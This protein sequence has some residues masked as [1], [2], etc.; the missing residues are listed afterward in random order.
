[1]TNKSAVLAQLDRILSSP[2]FR[3]SKRDSSLLRYLVE[4]TL[5]GE[6]EHLKERVLGVAVFARPADY[7]N[8]ADPVVRISAGET[9]KR[10]A[11]YYHGPGHEQ[12]IRIELPV[13][14][15]VPQFI[16]LPLPAE[17]PPATK[18]PDHP[19]NPAPCL[20]K[21]RVRLRP[22]LLIS[23]VLCV[24]V[25]TGVLTWWPPWIR[26][27]PLEQFW[28]PFLA[29][30]PPTTICVGR[31]RLIEDSQIGEAFNE[32]PAIAW[33]ETLALAKF[34]IFIGRE[35][36][37]CQ[38]RRDDNVTFQE[39]AGAPA[40]LI[41]GL[42]NVWVIR[43][44]EDLRFTLQAE[45]GVRFIRD[46][47]N[48]SSKAWSNPVPAAGQ[49]RTRDFGLITRLLESRSGKPVLVVSGTGGNG[50]DA[51]AEFVT[52]RSN[53]DLMARNAPVGWERKNLQIVLE[54]NVINGLSGPAK[55]VALHV[56]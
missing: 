12:E 41:G 39:L 31:R 25:F 24:V 22:P 27:T 44:T 5:E 28:R 16:E 26:T 8:S 49:Q 54:A 36:K 19:I 15:Y 17:A 2:S 13:G 33:P 1:M 53:I 37:R 50:L 56:W 43:L 35:D 18:E 14:S 6:T 29:W 7:D 52:D 11:Q 45:G 38:L 21:A 47:N 23:V 3:G 32:R 51:A 20:P 48:P 46:K 4:K 9:R 42:N 30:T 10:I 55:V 40:I 34:A